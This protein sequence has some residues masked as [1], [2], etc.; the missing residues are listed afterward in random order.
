M[1]VSIPM[2]SLRPNSLKAS[3]S[4]IFFSEKADSFSK[5]PSASLALP[6]EI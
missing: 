3:E 1:N 6:S 2:M 5:F 4:F